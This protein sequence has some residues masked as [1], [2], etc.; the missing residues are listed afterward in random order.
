METPRQIFDELVLTAKKYGKKVKIHLKDVDDGYQIYFEKT[1][2]KRTKSSLE[3]GDQST[4]YSFKKADYKEKF[5]EMY[6]EQ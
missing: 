2:E 6:Y 3:G 5:D 4:V 1:F